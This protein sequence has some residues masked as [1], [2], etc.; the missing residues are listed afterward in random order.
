LKFHNLVACALKILLL[1]LVFVSLHPFPHS[2]VVVPFF[3]VVHILPLP[4]L[5]CFIDNFLCNPWLSCFP[6]YFYNQTTNSIQYTFLY[7][8]PLYFYVPLSHLSQ[9]Q[10]FLP[11]YLALSIIEPVPPPD[12]TLFSPLL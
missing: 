12:P 2:S 3:F 9:H 5:I 7:I 4:S 10:V 1:S 11:E 8:L 6:F